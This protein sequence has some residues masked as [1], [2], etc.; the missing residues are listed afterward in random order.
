MS[1]RP[2][3]AAPFRSLDFRFLWS[4][5]L[6]SNLGGLIQA[7][8]AGWMMA[9]I[10]ASDDTVALVQAATTLPIVLFSLMAG[11]LADNFD[12]RRVLLAAQTLMMTASVIL[13]TLAFVGE[14][15]PWL[16][17]G[18]TFMIGCG[19]ALHNPSWQA[20][21]GDLVPRR[22]IPAAVTLNSMAFNLMRSIGPAVG[23]FVVASAG[24]AGAFAIN[25]L[26]YVPIILTLRRWQHRRPVS[27]LPRETLGD[28]MFAGLSFVAMSPNLLTV[29][30]R[31][32]SFGIG[33]VA[34]LALLPL[35][36]RDLVQGQATTF[37][38]LLGSF[39]IGGIGGALL[40]TRLREAFASETITRVAYMGFA[41][42]TV[43]VALSRDAWL[44]CLGLVPAGA[45][46]VLALS[47]F[48]VTVQLSTPRWVVGRALSIYQMA[49]FGGM[50]AGSWVWGILARDYGPTLALLCA[51]GVLTLG[52]FVGL[53]FPLPPL[54]SLDLDPLDQFKE[55]EVRLDLRSRSG[56]IMVL[57]D[58]E[59][60]QADVPAF[61]A[62]MS[63]RRRVRIRDGA[64]QWSLLRDLENPEIW[65]ETYHV[66]T[67]VE[68]VRHNTRRTKADAEIN[69]RLRELHKGPDRPRVHRM[70][71]RQTVPLR[72]DMPIKEY[73]EVS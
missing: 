16:L 59:I 17:L 31:S 69:D 6:V 60:A 50:A 63:E 47:L 20:S 52:A 14:V 28:A 26:S 57:V 58:Y 66:A 33:A 2:S 15:T 5:V 7:V 62:T 53:R 27:D 73:P 4:A 41:V 29:I 65:T 39:G 42:G 12:R 72:D 38:L 44:S 11:A 64:R 32:A 37:G 48:N 55:P 61:L 13:A 67:W 68:Y 25:A 46:W 56:P 24:A 43:V 8:G 21:I 9:T 40:N 51:G 54:V 1:D 45:C 36:A 70:I 23:G 3:L 71:E 22:D 35:V 30:L 19:T 34:I 10:G 49:T 18:F